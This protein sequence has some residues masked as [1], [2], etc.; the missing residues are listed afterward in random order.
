MVRLK[1]K[2]AIGILWMRPACEWVGLVGL[3]CELA[4]LFCCIMLM[5]AS[6]GAGMLPPT[7]PGLFIPCSGLYGED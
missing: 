7:P 3:T 5:E 2:L 1:H 4:G 6:V